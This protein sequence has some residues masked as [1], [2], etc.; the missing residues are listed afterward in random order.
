MAGDI[1]RGEC[2]WSGY[3]HHHVRL[4]AR[5]ASIVGRSRACH[6]RCRGGVLLAIPSHSC[7]GIAEPVFV[8]SVTTAIVA[9]LLS[10][11]HAAP[12][13]YVGGS[14]GTLIGADL[15]NLGNIR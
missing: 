1:N 12:L 5:Q 7:L 8:P 11:E 4:S 15:L 9:L 14:L 10:R 2:R 6:R 13:A 3:S